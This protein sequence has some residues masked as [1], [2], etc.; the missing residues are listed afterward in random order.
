MPVAGAGA[1]KQGAEAAAAVGLAH[2]T[3]SLV[4]GWL[5]KTFTTISCFCSNPLILIAVGFGVF[6]LAGLILGKFV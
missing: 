6:A 1:V 2:K 3:G 5:S 4:C